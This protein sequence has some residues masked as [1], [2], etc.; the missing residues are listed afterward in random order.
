MAAKRVYR[1]DSDFPCDRCGQP[2]RVGSEFRYRGLGGG[3]IEKV[4]YPYCPTTGEPA[5]S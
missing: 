1:A 3:Q 2:I 5:S 4:H